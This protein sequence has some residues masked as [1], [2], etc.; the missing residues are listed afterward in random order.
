MPETGIAAGARV[1]VRA[2]GGGQLSKIATT[3]IVMGYDFLVVWACG[4]DEWRAATAEG[5]E[6]DAIPWPANDV[7]LA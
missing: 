7:V 6:P 1:L 4:E 5:R 3:G 2:L